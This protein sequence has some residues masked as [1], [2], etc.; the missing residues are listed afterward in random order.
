VCVT[1]DIGKNRQTQQKLFIICYSRQ[2]VSTQLWGYLQAMN[3]NCRNKMYIK[4]HFLTSA[5]NAVDGQHHAPTALLPG[6]RPGTR[7]TGSWVGLRAS[8]DECRKFCLHWDSI[9]GPSIEMVIRLFICLLSVHSF[10]ITRL[11]ISQN[12]S[13]RVL[14]TH[15]LNSVFHEKRDDYSPLVSVNFRF[16]LAW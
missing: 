4:V 16:V 6:K 5:L 12:S 15:S 13:T 1:I 11:H 3:K 14:T 2:L 7:C 8:L 10:F 9:P